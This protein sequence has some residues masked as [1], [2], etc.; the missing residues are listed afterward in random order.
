MHKK[1][2]I[3]AMALCLTAS[4]AGAALA[5][6]GGPPPTPRG[7]Q[8]RP[9]GPVQD[10]PLRPGRAA[11]AQGRLPGQVRRDAAHRQQRRTKARTR[12]RVVKKKD[13]PRTAKQINN[14]KICQK[15]A[16]AHGADPNSDAPPK[17]LFLENGVGQDTPPNVDRPGDSG[18]TGPGKKGDVDRPEG[19]GEE[20]HEALLHVPHPSVDA[21]EGQR[22]VGRAS[23]RRHHAGPWRSPGPSRCSVAGA[24]ARARVRDYWVAAVPTSWNIVPNGHDAIMDMPVDRGR[25]DLPDGRLPPLH[26]AAGASRCPTRAHSSADGLA[27]PRPADPGARRRPAA[28]PLQEHGHAAPRPALDALPRRALP[29]ELRRRLRARLLRRA[30]PTSCPARRGRTG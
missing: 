24:G 29:A 28:R 4:G 15:I 11:L 22:Q 3:G 27:D 30:T 17:F 26:A 12:S 23:M 8:R 13:V 2:V 19:D 14:C 6:K 9:E 5:A 18:V 20:G 16:K 25:L 7:D 10:Q 1:V 21:G